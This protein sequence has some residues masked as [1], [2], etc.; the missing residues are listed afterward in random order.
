MHDVIQDGGW[1]I[2]EGAQ[3]NG[4]FAFLCDENIE[5]Q[6][7][8]TTM[9]HTMIAVL[10][11]SPI[12]HVLHSILRIES[13]QHRHPATGR[14][15]K[16]QRRRK[17]GDAKLPPSELPLPIALELADGSLVRTCLLEGA[18]VRLKIVDVT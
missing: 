6:G 13:S 3:L 12:Q 2:R 10:T 9:S 11:N 18:K 7:G 16:Q 1:R 17:K 5:K 15:L 14:A 8:V 4:A